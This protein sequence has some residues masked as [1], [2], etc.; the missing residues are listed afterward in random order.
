MPKTKEIYVSFRFSMRL[1]PTGQVTA[2]HAEL[3]ALTEDEDPDE[4][5]KV[6]AEKLQAAVRNDI[7][8]VVAASRK[9]R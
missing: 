1:E 8:Q 3:Q 6:L 5:R 2:E 9:S 7:A 4:A